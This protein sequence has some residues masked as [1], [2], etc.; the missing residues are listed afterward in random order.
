VSLAT[1]RRRWLEAVAELAGQLREL[2]G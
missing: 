2:P 1:A